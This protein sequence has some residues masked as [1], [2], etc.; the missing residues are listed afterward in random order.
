[1]PC[2]LLL[3]FGPLVASRE[4]GRGSAGI[5]IPIHET[6]TSNDMYGVLFQTR[7]SSETGTL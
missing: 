2:G 5:E 4:L 7:F 3:C 6:P 1:M